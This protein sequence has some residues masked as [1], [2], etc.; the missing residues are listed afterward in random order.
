MLS[1]TG[2]FPHGFSVCDVQRLV[3]KILSGVLAG[4]A[5]SDADG[6]EASQ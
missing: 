3:A 5:A 6:D 1:G 4:N 2:K